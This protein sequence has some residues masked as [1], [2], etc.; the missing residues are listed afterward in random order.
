MG[1]FSLLVTHRTAGAG[2]LSSFTISPSQTSLTQ[3][4]FQPEQCLVFVYP[5][6]RGTGLLDLFAHRTWENGQ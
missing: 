3:G 6:C 2:V 4:H 5:G 1:Y